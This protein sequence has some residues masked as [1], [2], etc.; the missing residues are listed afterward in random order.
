MEFRRKAIDEFGEQDWISAKMYCTKSEYNRLR[1]IAR[2]AGV[3]EAGAVHDIS[4]GT[5]SEIEQYK[6]GHDGERLKL[7]NDKLV[8]WQRIT[9][10][11]IRMNMLRMG[12]KRGELYDSIEPTQKKNKYGEIMRIGFTF[13]RHGI[14]IYK[15]AYEGYGGLKGSR[16]SYRK[17]TE[18]GYINTSQMRETNR[19]SIGRLMESRMKDRDWFN[20][21]I[22]KR[23]ERLTE[24]CTDYCDMMIVDASKIYIKR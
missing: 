7:Y 15:G 6:R 9:I 18:H 5:V 1:R 22:E 19:T 24:I 10:G 12:M 14:F 20:S 23:M 4:M 8:E 21:V 2:K 11:S 13:A 3:L 17:K 16:W